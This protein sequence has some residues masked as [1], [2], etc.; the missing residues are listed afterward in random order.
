MRESLSF[1]S[2]IPVARHSIAIIS[3][4]AVISK[5]SSC[6]TPLFTP[7]NPITIDRSDLSFMS[8]TRCH[9]TLLGS[10]SRSFPWCM[11]L[12]IIAASRL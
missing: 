8:I 11:W 4:A 7:P 9:S 12:L 10:I 5:R 1:R 3:L 6:G 2:S